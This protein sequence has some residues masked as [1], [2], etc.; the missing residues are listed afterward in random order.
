MI[1]RPRPS[2]F[3]AA[4]RRSSRPGGPAD[5]LR[6]WSRWT[7]AWFLSFL[8]PCATLS[9]APL[10]L[11][12]LPASEWSRAHAAHLASRAG[13]GLDGRALQRL[14]EMP[15]ETAVEQFLH[16]RFEALAAQPEFDP[17]G[18]FE[19]GLDPFPP[20]RPATTD[21]AQR[22]GH[23]L[24]ITVRPGGN[25]PLQPIVN[26]FFYW[27]RASRLETDRVA[28]WWA[29]RM[30]AG[31]DPL[32]EKMALFWHGHFATNED[33]VRDYRKMLQQLQLFQRA[34]LGRF[35]ELLTEVSKD[36]AMLVFLDAGV[37]TKDSPNENFAREIM[38]LFTMGVGHYTE[39]DVQEAARAFTGWN[40]K[41]LGFEVLERDHDAGPKTFLGRQGSFD[42]DQIIAIILEQPVTARF[43]A[44]KL[45]RYFVNQ[46][47]DDEAQAQLGR[48]LHE[49]DYD[50]GAFLGLLFRSR[51]FY[52]EAN[53]GSRIKSPVEL[54]ISTYRHLG[55]ARVPGVP[56]FPHVGQALGQRLMHPPTVA[57]WSQGTSWIT[58]SLLFERSNFVLDVLFP[59][60]GFI[61]PDRYPDYPSDEIVH[62]QNRLRQGQSISAAT[63]PTGVG[64]Q[65]MSA[66]NLSADRNEAFNT[67]LGSMR[68]WQ[69]A[70]ERVKPIDRSPARLDLTGQV[71]LAGAGNARAVVDYF[72]DRFF[73]VPPD[74]GA[75]DR[76]AKA[77]I[78]ELGTDDMQAASSFL[79]EPCAS[80]CTSCSACLNTSLD[81]PSM[82]PNSDLI[83]RRMI[84]AGVAAAVS[85]WAGAMP[86]AMAAG[87]RN[88]ETDGREG[89]PPI[90]VVVELSGGND[91]L[92]S[93][94][95]FGDDAYYRHRPK[96][97]IREADTLR[98]DAH[99]GLNP[100]M[101]GFH[102]LWQESQLAIIHGC[103]YAQ[104]SYSHFTSMAYWHTGAPNRGDAL[105]WV[106]R[107]ADS[108]AD[109]RR[110]N[111]IINV[112]ASQSLAVRSAVHTPVVF[113][114]PERFARYQWM[115]EP[116]RA[117][118]SGPSGNPARDFLRAV[119]ASARASSAL[120]GDAW[121]RYQTDVDYGLVPM[122]LPKVAACI[123]AGLPTQLY[124]VSYRNN[125]FDTHV[126]QPALHR[127]LLS[128]ACDGVFGFIRDMRRLGMA[129]RVL[130]MVFSEF[131]RRVTENA[132]LGTD[133]GTANVMFLAGAPVRGGHY[134][135][136]P[137]LTDLADD[138]LRHTTDFRRVYATV[139]ERW[140]G[141][142]SARVLKG[143]FEPLPGVIKT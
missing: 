10:D 4:H 60:I 24:G 84:R 34:G 31:G 123:A 27:L 109:T 100:G 28:W 104:P 5:R 122:D 66:S 14:A 107:L 62:V 95:P 79:E 101:L 47:L 73:V 56:D 38:E 78:A 1:Q 37:N 90:L 69:M 88:P 98:L 129:E 103:G 139:I 51:E 26:K 142:D 42:G 116:V 111:M 112:A 118:A 110:E 125:A 46:Q 22:Q 55:L 44:G 11:S 9:A 19:P 93:V 40:F 114:E 36:P 135:E 143:A 29:N 52:R 137:S 117:S 45:Y 25:R 131:G 72:V 124:Y 80:C 58:P 63:R 41:G 86:V 49:R 96:I 30:L 120:I 97:G 136:A 105:G 99:Y 54:M 48:A 76:A 20:S 7:I 81:S 87:N 23:A 141:A 130:V 33:K 2:L 50:I 32:R 108:M 92:N 39:K 61:A 8:L 75:L 43:I 113:Q 3:V 132:N 94:V 121:G 106:G 12:P 67:R 35:G 71:L 15:M 16:G 57:G 102:R 138:N 59:D 68:G 70:I 133:H 13:F 140:L 21:M 119:D 6:P 65:M 91:G 115:Q 85:P 64:K 17:S 134:G 82:K 74:D 77:L 53:R 89:R 83:R 126:N 18:V 128:Y 127:R